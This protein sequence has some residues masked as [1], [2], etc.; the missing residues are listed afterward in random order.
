[1][2]FEVFV[3]I[4]RRAGLQHHDVDP[5]LGQHLRGGS[6]GRTRADDAHVVHLRGT[7]HLGHAFLD[8]GLEAQ[9][10][11]ILVAGFDALQRVL[12][13]IVLDEV[14]LDASF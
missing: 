11:Q 14:M 3:W 13:I 12:R 7:D 2:L 8:D 9:L 4:E 5:A 1:M 6:A 10:T